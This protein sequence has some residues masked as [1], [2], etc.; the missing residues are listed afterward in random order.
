MKLN[1]SKLTIVLA[2]LVSQVCT[3]Q[4]IQEDF[5]NGLPA[6][7]TTFTEANFD[8]AFVTSGEFNLFKQSDGDE[9]LMLATEAYDLS[10]FTKMEIDIYGFNLSFSSNTLPE[11]HFGYLESENDF[12]SF[13]SIHTFKVDNTSIETREVFLGNLDKT[14]QLVFKL[15]GDPSHIVYIDNFKL[16]DD[17]FE[18]NIPAAVDN[19]EFEPILDG[20]NRV[21]ASWTNP[22]LE[23]D[24]DILT[25][26]KSVEFALNGASFFSSI[27]PT[28]GGQSTETLELPNAGFYQFE[29]TPTNSAGAGYTVFSKKMWV[30]LDVPAEVSN[31]E[32]VRNDTQVNL[33]WTA[34]TSGANEVFFDGIV[35]SYKVTRSDGKVFIIPGSESSFIDI[36]DIQGSI[37]YTITPENVSGSGTSATSDIIYYVSDDFLYYED[38]FVNVVERPSESLDYDYKWTTQSTTTGAFWGHFQSSFNGTDAGELAYLWGT[39]TN[40]NDIVRAV[41]PVIN[42]TGL[43]AIAIEYNLYAEFPA[44]PIIE[45][46]LE[47]TSDGGNTWQLVETWQE[48]V[49]IQE[50]VLKVIGNSDVGSDNFQF[51]IAVKGNASVANFGRIDNIRA[52][53]QPSID[54][55]TTKSEIPTLVEPG[56][57]VSLTAEVEN[58]STEVTSGTAYLELRDKFNNDILLQLDQEVIDLGIGEKR[59]LDFGTWDGVEGE[60]VLNLSIINTEDENFDNNTISKNLDV[61]QLTDKQLVL[62]EEFTGT[63]C[64]ACP[65]A[66]LGIED[67]IDE[68]K[69]VAAVAYHR[70]DPY[71]TAIVQEKIDLYNILGF[72]TV[73]VDGVVSVIGGDNTTS[74]VQLYRTPVD[75]AAQQKTPVSL[76]ILGADLINNQFTGMVEIN[77]LS[78]IQNENYVLRATI[79]E[80]EIEESW[81]GL[82]I[83]DFVQRTYLSETIDLSSNSD[84][85]NIELTVPPMID[86][87]HLKLVA[88]VQD[89]ET[90]QVYNTV[91]S[92]V[93]SI[94]ANKNISDNNINIYPNPAMD[95]LVLESEFPLGEITVFTMQGELVMKRNIKE[96]RRNL[97]ISQL[98][99]GPYYI[100]INASGQDGYSN[101]RFVKQ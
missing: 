54:L 26:L 98:A 72:P 95:E 62:I 21:S 12:S 81:Q 3:A 55:A 71:E 43:P 9:V 27:N 84:L 6:G 64:S 19:L 7:W 93:F 36:L 18:N 67:L 1:L 46:T 73:I 92:D 14:R 63:W 13:S 74:V 37:T 38:F 35:D 59:T 101:Y 94:V 29:V 66:S 31:I 32:I 91:E 52:Y 80:N 78:S 4:V 48:D 30:G 79:I 88:W 49:S 76:E 24:G 89:T 77:S 86:N 34:P 82:D 17:V 65:G 100:S 28:I 60:Y 85:I 22:S 50:A 51:A 45:F 41:S 11:M 53:Y 83:L 44:N 57:V 16:Y 97:N 10:Q 68:G 8:F 25:D 87:S 33:N 2:F 5:N 40:G 56:T 42:T 96:S 58:N 69:P 39:P 20:T 47:T 15:E 61:F 90:N 23:V 75:E 70:S 99:P